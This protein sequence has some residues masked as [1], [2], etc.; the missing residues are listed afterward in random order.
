LKEKNSE[1]LKKV[2]EDNEDVIFEEEEKPVK[3]RVLPP[4]PGRRKA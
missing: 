2:E 3:R 4:R 1:F